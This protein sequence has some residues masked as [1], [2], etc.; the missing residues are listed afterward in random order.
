MKIITRPP[1]IDLVT[2]LVILLFALLTGAAPRSTTTGS[3]FGPLRPHEV[4][5]SEFACT[6][7]RVNKYLGDLLP[8]NPH[9]FA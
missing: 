8:L 1:S 9:R 6:G 5:T 3:R 2:L 7:M 4:R